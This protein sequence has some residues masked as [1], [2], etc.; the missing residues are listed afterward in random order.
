M[1]ALSAKNS[2][3]ARVYTKVSALLTYTYIDRIICR[4]RTSTSRDDVVEMMK[5]MSSVLHDIYFLRM[6]D[7]VRHDVDQKPATSKP[8]SGVIE[9][10]DARS[11]RI[12]SRHHYH[13]DVDTSIGRSGGRSSGVEPGSKELLYTGCDVFQHQTILKRYNLT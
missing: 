3:Y 11:L 13:V 8:H 2:Q 4:K 5:G 9:E 1:C 10:C 7:Q 6:L 12:E